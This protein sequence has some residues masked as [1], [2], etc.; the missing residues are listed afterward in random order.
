MKVYKNLFSNMVSMESLL[1]AWD[2]FKKGKRNKLDVQ[3]FEFQL[4]DNLFRLHRDLINKRYGHG[5]Y[6]GFYIRDPK[7]RRIH[8]AQV[9]DRIVHH[10]IS[11][12]LNP[13]FEPTFIADSYSCRKNKGTHRGIKRLEVFARKVYQTYG[14][15]FVLKCDIKKFFPTLN[16]R[17]LLDIISRRIKDQDVLWLIKTIVESFYSEFSSREEIKGAPIGNLTSQLFANIYMLYE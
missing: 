15:C 1:N 11:Q 4:E 14:H 9:R 7:I 12:H 16:H 3:E 5:Q 10:T 6:K 2:E 8:K 17:I 13:I